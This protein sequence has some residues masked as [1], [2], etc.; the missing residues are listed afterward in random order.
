MR[1]I[2]FRGKRTDNGNWAYGYYAVHRMMLTGEM[3]YFIVVDEQRP[4]SVDPETVGQYTGLKDKAGTPIYEG[5]QLFAPG[6]LTDE[7]Q[8]VGDVVWDEADAR[9]EVHSFHGNFEYIPN[10]E[11]VVKGN[12]YENKKEA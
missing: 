11:C 4:Q 10:G 9:W 5:D 3:D 8:Y 1:E 6:N 7:L 2:K 12:I